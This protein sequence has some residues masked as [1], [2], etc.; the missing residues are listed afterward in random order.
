M[1]PIVAVA[2]ILDESPGEGK[3]FEYPSSRMLDASCFFGD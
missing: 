1:S 3:K 2:A